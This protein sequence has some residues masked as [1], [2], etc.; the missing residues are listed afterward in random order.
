M[1]ST[2]H[3]ASICMGKFIITER[4]KIIVEVYILAASV[5]RQLSFI[6]VEMDNTKHVHGSLF[7]LGTCV[8]QYKYVQQYL[9]S[10][11]GL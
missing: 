9:L 6:V 4:K 10:T 11:F 8:L 7:K 1:A 5:N 2:I 3:I